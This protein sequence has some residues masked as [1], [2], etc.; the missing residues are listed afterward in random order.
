MAIRYLPKNVVRRLMKKKNMEKLVSRDLTLNRA[1]VQV[2]ERTGVLSK[3][4]LETVALKVIK[5]YKKRYKEEIASGASRSAALEDAVAGRKQL[6]QRVQNAAIA[7]IASEIKDQYSGEYYEWLPSDAEEPDPEHQLNYGKVFQI[8][9]GEM[10]GDRYGC[11][12]GMNILVDKTR[13]T[14]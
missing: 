11:K 14:L 2:L 7:E 6:V 9:V 10:P 1:A 13:L 12:C 4:K 5:G 8:G 3:D